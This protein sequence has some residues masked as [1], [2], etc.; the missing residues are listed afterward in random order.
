MSK[1]RDRQKNWGRWGNL[2]EREIQREKVTYFVFVV[3]FAAV[4]RKHF[5]P[6]TLMKH[7]K[8]SQKLCNNYSLRK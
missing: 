3:F 7:G 4:L 1:L 8:H 6:I 2:I 5:E